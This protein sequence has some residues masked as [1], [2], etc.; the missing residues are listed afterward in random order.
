MGRS[1]TILPTALIDTGSRT[2]EVIFG[3]LKGRSTFLELMTCLPHNDLALVLRFFL[4]D[5]R[6]KC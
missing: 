6:L 2:D 1:L 4:I 3:K 5:P